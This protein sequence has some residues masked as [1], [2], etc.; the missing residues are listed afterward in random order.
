MG[1][2][3]QVTGTDFLICTLMV[4]ILDNESFI[5]PERVKVFAF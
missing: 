3:T 2:L 5:T 4:M 1:V